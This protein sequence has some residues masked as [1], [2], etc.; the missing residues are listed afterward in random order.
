M[1]TSKLNKNSKS[2]YTIC[3]IFIALLLFQTQL[4]SASNNEKSTLI[5][6]LLPS[7][8][9]IT[10]FKRYAPLRDYLAK[11][12]NRKINLETA[13]NFPEFIKRTK[14]G[15]YDFLE[16]APHFVIP[17]IDSKKYKVITTI[18]QPLTAQIVVLKNSQYTKLSQ[19]SV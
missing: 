6:G 17:A 1:K 15:R 13:R 10:K 7:E 5:F 18:I 11:K 3:T 8:S 12:L 16:T 14:E 9:A 19:L 2:S 4:C